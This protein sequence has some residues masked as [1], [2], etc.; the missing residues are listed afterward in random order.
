M[1]IIRTFAKETWIKVLAIS[2][3]YTLHKL[4]TNE[5]KAFADRLKQI[6]KQGE[7]MDGVWLLAWMNEYYYYEHKSCRNWNNRNS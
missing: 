4:G 2:A 3:V 7:R 6:N 1:H 5:I